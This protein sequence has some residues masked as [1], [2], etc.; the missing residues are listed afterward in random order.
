VKKFLTPT[1]LQGRI[2]S[3]DALY[4]QTRFC[5]EVIAAGG[6]YLLFVKQNQPLFSEDVS[7]FFANL[8]WTVWIGAPLR[9]RTKDMDE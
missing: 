9:P 1:V 3:S 6:D 7:L 4:A 5:Q 2:M 8:L